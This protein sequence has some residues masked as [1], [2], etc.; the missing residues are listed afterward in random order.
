MVLASLAQLQMLPLISTTC[1]VKPVIQ[2]CSKF[3]YHLL[4]CFSQDENCVLR[5]KNHVSRDQLITVLYFFLFTAQYCFPDQVLNIH[6]FSMLRSWLQHL[7]FTT[8]TSTS[9][10]PRDRR[11]PVIFTT[12][13]NPGSVENL[14]QSTYPYGS[15]SHDN[16]LNQS[17]SSMDNVSIGSQSSTGFI[18]PLSRS[19]PQ[20]SE[21]Q[22]L[23]Q[24]PILGRS[25]DD[26]SPDERSSGSDSR[27][28]TP[29]NF[30]LDPGETGVKA[31][32]KPTSQR[33]KHLRSMSSLSFSKLF[34]SSLHGAKTGE[35]E[36][37]ERACEYCLRLL[38]QS[39]RSK[40]CVINFFF[41]KYKFKKWKLYRQNSTFLLSRVV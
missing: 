26:R 29:L 20:G 38:E 30:P 16:T 2:Y 33:G 21:N 11:S 13:S 10:S 9:V 15:P 32:S 19:S 36:L 27:P 37:K 8:T 22:S 14:S 6:S 1:Y 31:Q 28:Q 24:S 34:P 7:T 18:I 5:Y 25:P 3:S 23:T 4:P 12:A 41:L 40:K 17:Q 35:Q 39:E